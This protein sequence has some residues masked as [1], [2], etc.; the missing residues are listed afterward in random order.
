MNNSVFGKTM[1]NIRKDNENFNEFSR[2]WRFEIILNN[3]TY[4]YFL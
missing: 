2:H 3:Q 1:E 4:K